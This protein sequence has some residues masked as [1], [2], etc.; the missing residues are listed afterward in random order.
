MNNDTKKPDTGVPL[1]RLVIGLRAM[2][3]WGTGPGGGGGMLDEYSRGKSTAELRMR[4]ELRRLIKELESDNAKPSGR[5]P[6]EDGG[7]K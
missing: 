6:Q 3:R 4:T 1:K 2:L 7:A 5:A